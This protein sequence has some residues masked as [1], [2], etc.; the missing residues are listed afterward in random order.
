MSF[1]GINY[2]TG[3]ISAGTTT[4]EPFDPD[5]V[6]RE[7]QIIHDD[8]HCTAVRITGGYPERLEVA[9]AHAA[10]A[11][12]EVW[13]CPFT[14]N[15][16]GDE[17][18]DLLADC[19]DRA[20][21]LRK[22]GAEIVFLTGSEL[23]LMT[24]GIIPGDTLMDRAAS[25]AD[26]VRLRPMIPEIRAR[27]KEL[28][29]KAVET[30][31]ARFGGKLSYASIPLDGVDWALFDI[32][33]TDAG[34]RTAAMAAHF[35]DNIRSFVEQGRAQGK[36]VAITEFGCATFRG[37]AD[38]ADRG[39]TDIVEWDD[40]ARP[41][42]LKREYERDEN[43]QARYIT[44]LLDVFSAEGVDSVFV[45]TFARYDLANRRASDQDFDL[46]SAGLVKVFDEE[47]RG[48][49]YPDMRWEPKA[50]FTAL[51]EYYRKNQP[52]T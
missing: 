18:L 30:V 2:D 12:L 46:A 50:A 51:A 7:M 5:V 47:H 20:E 25:L 17:L 44:E 35:R 11:G 19:A 15:L 23:S 31:R 22:R 40:K 10:E 27:M 41:V 39:I 38:L 49:R 43:E 9:A 52:V 14:N 1:K 48:Q 4:R 3:F 26:P 45:Y 36:P 21:A 16:T 13:F 34:Y 6:K 8:L 37:A 28:L 32:I 42:R 33:S 29:R 24:A